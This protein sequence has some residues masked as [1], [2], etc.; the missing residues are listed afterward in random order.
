MWGRKVKFRFEFKAILIEVPDIL[1]SGLLYVRSGN[2][3]HWGKKKG[4]TLFFMYI[5]I[6]YGKKKNLW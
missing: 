2:C 1:R 5:W 3:I 6:E 4:Y